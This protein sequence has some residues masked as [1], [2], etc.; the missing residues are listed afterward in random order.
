MSESYPVRLVFATA[1]GLSNKPG[2][3]AVIDIIE[4]IETH[5]L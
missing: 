5:V 3:R 2:S 4:E 1:P